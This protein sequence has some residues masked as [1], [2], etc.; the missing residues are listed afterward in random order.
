MSDY[1]SPCFGASPAHCDA[2]LGLYDGEMKRETCPLTPLTSCRV[3]R[4]RK[5]ARC[6]QAGMGDVA[7]T[8]SERDPSTK[9]DIHG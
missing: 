2:R 6:R 4:G 7:Y 3:L 5:G 1:P 9:A 8:P